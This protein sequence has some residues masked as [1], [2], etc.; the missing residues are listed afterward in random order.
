M[1]LINSSLREVIDVIWGYRIAWMLGALM[2]IVELIMFYNP[3]YHTPPR[4]TQKWV[5][6]QTEKYQFEMPQPFRKALLSELALGVSTARASLRVL[7]GVS[8]QH[9]WRAGLQVMVVSFRTEE[10]GEAD[11]PTSITADGNPYDMARRAHQE[12]LNALQA[13]EKVRQLQAVQSGVVQVNKAYALRTN[14]TGQAQHQVPSFQAPI[15][16]FVMTFPLSAQEALVF[17]AQYPRE[18]AKH[19]RPVFE[20]IVQSFRT[21]AS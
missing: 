9:S 5:P 7:E 10:S 2:L 17:H 11:A 21:K 8:L 14:F 16:G 4:F 3:R 15:E 6:A 12:Y 19:Y 18:Q 13:G 20:R 1:S